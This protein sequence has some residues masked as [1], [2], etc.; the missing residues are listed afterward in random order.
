MTKFTSVAAAMLALIAAN[1]TAQTT[2]SQSTTTVTTPTIVVPQIVAPP[3]GTLSTTRTEKTVGADGTMTDTTSSTYRN[4]AGVADDTVSK[5]TV[6]PPAMV[7]T[8]TKTTT[9][10]TKTP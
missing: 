9:T 6:Y 5:T 8:D 1:A 7:T 10:I 2:T 4:T 3:V